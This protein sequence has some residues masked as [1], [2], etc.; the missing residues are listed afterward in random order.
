MK[1]NHD[2][3]HEKSKKKLSP[4]VLVFVRTLSH[5]KGKKIRM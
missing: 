1:E 4:R 2:G 3:R 5:K